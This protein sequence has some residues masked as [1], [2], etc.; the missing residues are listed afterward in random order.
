[1]RR[2]GEGSRKG[3]EELYICRTHHPDSLLPDIDSYGYRGKIFHPDGT[4]SG[5]LHR[6][7]INPIA[8]L[9]AN[10]GF[11]IPKAQHIP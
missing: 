10:D 5:V 3:G 1:M 2:G 11:G 4:D 9:C 7:G 8:Y 6:G